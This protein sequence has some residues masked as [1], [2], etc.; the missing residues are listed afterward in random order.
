MRPRPVLSLGTREVGSLSPCFLIASAGAA[1]EG[2]SDAAL[3][4]IEAAF[5]MGADGILF[6]IFRS[7]ELV[8]RRHPERR[9]FE[10]LELRPREW[11]KIFGAARA[12]G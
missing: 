5:P 6:T 7:A 11:K 9:H 2:A 10:S 8:V 12:S 3:K 4:M 1:H